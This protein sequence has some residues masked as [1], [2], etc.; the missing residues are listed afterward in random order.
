MGA[1]AGAALLLLVAIVCLNL[2]DA[3]GKT[4]LSVLVHVDSTAKI[5]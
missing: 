1:V 3:Q 4:P 5:K 2:T